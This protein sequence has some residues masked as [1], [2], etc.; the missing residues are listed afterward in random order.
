MRHQNKGFSCIYERAYETPESA[1]FLVT[2]V[3]GCKGYQIHYTF[4]PG[5]L[6]AIK[7]A[8]IFN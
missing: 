7:D 5:R 4:E 6:V 2:A 8:G 3:C 1:Y